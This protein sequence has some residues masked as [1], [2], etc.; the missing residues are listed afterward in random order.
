[1]K[2][3]EKMYEQLATVLIALAGSDWSTVRVSAPVLRDHCGGIKISSVTN[4]GEKKWLKPTTQ[5]IS[6]IN[7]TFLS[8]RD[9]LRGRSGTTIWSIDFDL[10]NDGKMLAK[11]GYEKPDWYDDPDDS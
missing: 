2:N 8:I 3:I 5:A 7:E 6:I 11:F 9:E 4:A 1:M 10:R